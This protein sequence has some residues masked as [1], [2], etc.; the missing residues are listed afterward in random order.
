VPVV[1]WLGGNILKN[2]RITIDFANQMTY[3]LR[4]SDP[5]PH[6]LDQVGLT[7]L[8]VG[9]NYLVAGIAS[10]DGG[11][12]VAGINPRD[13][14]IKIDAMKVTGASR[15]AVLSALHGKPGDSRAI[16][17]DRDGKEVT[18]RAQVKRF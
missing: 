9:D 15:D 17:V 2:F 1:G 16:T 8:A 5:N 11:L 7:L 10:Q 13:R 4:Q 14:L 3:W 18:V 12:T 6:D